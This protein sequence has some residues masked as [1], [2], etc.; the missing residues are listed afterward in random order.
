MIEMIIDI[1]AE[2]HS[3]IIVLIYIVAVAVEHLLNKTL[4]VNGY[5]DQSFHIYVLADMVG[6]T[7]IL[8]ILK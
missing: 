4:R 3:N 7:V 6:K 5:T 2:I 1:R 8:L